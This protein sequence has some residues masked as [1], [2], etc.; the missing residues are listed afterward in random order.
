MAFKVPLS[1]P[2]IDQADIDAVVAVLRSP[3]LSLG[4]KLDAFERAFAGYIGRRRAV[5]VNSGTSG[6]FLCTQA[7]GLGAGD[8]VITTPFTF[9]A[10]ATTIMMAGA[11]PVFVDID[12]VSL[13]MDP[14]GVEAAITERTR[15]VLPVVI[16]GNPIGLDAVCDLA[17]AHDLPIIEDS[18]EGLGSVL[19]S[20]KIGTFGTMSVFAFYPNKQMTTGEGGMIVTDDDEL[21]DLCVSLRNQGR[22]RGGGWLAHERLGYNYRLSD[23]NCALG[24]SQLA[25]LDEF[26]E[27]RR[28]VARMY[29]ERLAGENRL[30][31]PT[32]PEGCRMSWFVFVVRL[33]EGYTADQRNALL[34]RLMDR[35]IQVSNYFPPVYLQPFMVERFGYKPGD[36][37]VTDAVCQSTVALPFHNRLTREQVDLVCTELQAA[38]DEM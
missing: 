2:D 12:P 33:A 25:R 26:V 22:G 1:R 19:N 38:L 3:T 32:E 29:A 23:I 14:A 11:R 36:F 35:G 21:A 5:A 16:F 7:L 6:L 37:P 30:I 34:S 17:A 13:N 8:E 20:R 31:V 18:C 15:A 4:P 27:A 28:R 10:S 9:I 24:L